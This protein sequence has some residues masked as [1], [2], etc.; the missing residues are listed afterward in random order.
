MALREAISADGTAI[1]YRVAGPDDGR[2]LVL[3]HGWAASLR[4]WGEDLVGKL[5]QDNRVVAMDLRGHGYS[6]VAQ[7]YDDPADWAADVAAVLAA[8]S[9]TR[10]AV[11]LGWSYGGLVICDYLAHHG[12][13]AV[14]GVVLTGA[15]N[16]IG[17]EVEGGRIGSAMQAA[18]PNVFA[19]D[20]RTAIRGLASFGNANTGGRNDGAIAQLLFGISLSTPPQV[21]EGMFRRKADHD[22]LLRTLDI[23]V[24]LMHG[25][26]DPV[27]DIAASEHA[28]ALLPA[29]QTSWWEGAQHGLFI[30][31]PDRFAAEVQAFIAGLG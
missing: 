3:I 7:R 24:L 26:A 21:R 6:G 22:D 30:E 18:I 9:T 13:D 29:A 2:P 15:I 5:A 10:D 20:P 8:E 14:A 28:A 11:L 19:T 25:T 17:R 31:D 16:A 4:C 23:P 1:A 27:V 12:T